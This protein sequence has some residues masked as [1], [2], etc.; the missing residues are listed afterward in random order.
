[1]MMG[2]N[3]LIT[4]AGHRLGGALA[5]KF[6]EKG[7]NV[8]VHYNSSKAK[9]IATAEACRSYGVKAIPVKADISKPEEMREIFR[10]L[11]GMMGNLDLLI[12]NAGVFPDRMPLADVSIEQWD[13][14]MNTNLRSVFL[15]SREFIKYAN[16]G[17]RIIN[18]ASIGGQEVWKQRTMYNVS[19]AGVLQ[20]TKA[21]ANELAP[22]ISVNSVSPV[23]IEFPEE[24]T[25]VKLPP[26]EKI[27][28]GRYGTS[29]DV[30]DCVYFFATC[31]HYITGQNLNV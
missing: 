19:K 24:E 17:A 23:A 20:L 5:R 14:T 21:L 18:I 1:M 2:K 6:A 7:Y 31:S 27:P 4:G 11:V 25:N 22:V 26:I 30:F 12:N 8:L 29:D 3:V 15:T 9:A 10:E 16:P 28:M 13:N